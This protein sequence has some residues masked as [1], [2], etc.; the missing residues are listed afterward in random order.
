[1]CTRSPSLKADIATL[2]KVQKRATKMIRTIKDQ[3]Y[4]DRL[5]ALGLTSL[6]DRRVRGDLIQMYK[7]V[8]GLERSN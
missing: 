4:E 3:S 7:I 8:N 5:R 1:M 2:K 6:E